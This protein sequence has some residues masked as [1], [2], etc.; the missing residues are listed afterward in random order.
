[1][2]GVRDNIGKL[3]YATLFVAII[4]PLLVAWA[5]ATADIIPL[6]VPPFRFVGFI[7]VA[8]GV[9]LMLAGTWAL[10]F[11]GGGL[12]MSPYP[13]PVYVSKGVYRLIPHPMYVG[14]TVLCFGIAMITESPSGFWLVSSCVA[15]GCAALV[16]GFERYEIRRR[17]G[18]DAVQR[19]LISL[20]VDSTDPPTGWDR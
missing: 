19:T 9:F 2:K 14:F 8:V 7:L 17:F 15:L 1:M 18:E 13:P 10:W 12:P 11:H 4:P 5:I 20:P 16:L 3:A 6:P